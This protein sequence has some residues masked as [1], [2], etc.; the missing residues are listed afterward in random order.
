MALRRGIPSAQSL[1]SS[2]LPRPSTAQRLARTKL[3]QQRSASKPSNCDLEPNDV[4]RRQAQF[5]QQLDL[6]NKRKKDKTIKRDNKAIQ[7]LL[8]LIY[9]CNQFDGQSIQPRQGGVRDC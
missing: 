7:E 4:T 9:E 6:R 2:A 1:V 8:D 3:K 5:Q